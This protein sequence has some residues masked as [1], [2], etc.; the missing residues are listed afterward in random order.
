MNAIR[1]AFQPPNNQ[2]NLRQ[3]LK[4]LRQTGTVQEYSSQFRNILGQIEDMSQLDQVSYF[5]DGLKPAT[6]AEVG[7]QA[8]TTF[9]QA[10]QLA[11]CFDNAMYGALRVDNYNSRKHDWYKSQAT[12][13]EVD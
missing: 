13:M 9:E 7:Y 3:Q 11:I 8:P 5:L 1:T 2:Q 10:W 4:H 6:R 12:P